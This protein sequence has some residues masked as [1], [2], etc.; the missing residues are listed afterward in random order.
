GRT[1]ALAGDLYG[2]DENS[3]SAVVVWDLRKR[4]PRLI[5]DHARAFVQYMDFAPDGRSLLTLGFVDTDAR[6]WDP[7][8]GTLRQTI[9]LCEPGSYHVHAVCFAPDSRHFAAAMG[10][11]T[12]YILRVEPGPANVAVVTRRPAAAHKVSEAPA[13]LW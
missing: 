6:I 12:V 9:H 3:K 13:D 4:Q 2:P 10:N 1:L 8:D 11:G 7:R 5:L